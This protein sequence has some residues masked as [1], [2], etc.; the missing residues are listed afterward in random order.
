[1]KGVCLRVVSNS[2]FE[3]WSQLYQS[4]ELYGK[5][6]PHQNSE[7]HQKLEF[8]RQNLENKQVVE[9]VGSSDRLLDDATKCR[10]DLGSLSNGGN[11]QCDYYNFQ[12][13]SQV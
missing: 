2:T 13:I 5:T 11:N 9:R 8:E 1:M 12:I 7:I 6:E 10:N 3:T 4:S